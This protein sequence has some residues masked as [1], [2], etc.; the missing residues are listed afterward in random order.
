MLKHMLSGVLGTVLLGGLAH[1][2]HASDYP[3]RSIKVIVPFAAGGGND[4]VGR[5]VAEKLAER[6]GRPVI[7]ENRVGAGGNIGAEAVAKAEPDGYT[8]LAGAFVAH[9]INMTLQKKVIRYDLDKDFAPIS[10][11]GVVPLT[12]VVHPSMPVKTAQEFITYVNARPG[13]VTYASAGAGST[14][15]LAAE[16]FKLMTKTQMRHVPYKGSAPAVNDLLGGHVNATFE[17]GPVVL[18][19]AQAGLLRPLMVANRQRLPELP[20]VPTAAEVGLPGFEVATQYGFL[21]PAGTPQPIVDRLSK[22]IA[23][24]LRLPAVQAKLL[25]QGALPVSST[26]EQTRTLLREEVAKW[27]KV[28]DEGG[29]QA[30]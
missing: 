3:N 5:V 19:Q 27:A 25:Q 6:L 15:H 13:E 8:L 29:I 26:P 28:I 1:P 22:E 10:L 12:L 16:M 30:Q 24:I 17:T 20:D 7:I 18:S 9:A 23:E 2:A 4:V 14:Q 11:A 21:A